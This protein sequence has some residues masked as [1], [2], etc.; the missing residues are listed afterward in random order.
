MYFAAVVASFKEIFK[1]TQ[2]VAEFVLPPPLTEVAVDGF[3]NHSF[4]DEALAD[5]LRMCCT[6]L[7][8]QA[9]DELIKL[10]ITAQLSRDDASTAEVAQY[11][12]KACKTLSEVVDRSENPDGAQGCHFPRPPATCRARSVS[13]SSILGDRKHAHTK[14]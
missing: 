5:D 8:S 9:Q 13:C 2:D 4:G 11:L 1:L 12:C 10:G 6:K 7:P 3:S 14:V